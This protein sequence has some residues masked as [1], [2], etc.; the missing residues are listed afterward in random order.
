M[1]GAFSRPNPD[2]D[3]DGDTDEWLLDAARRARL[4]GPKGDRPAGTSAWRMLLLAGVAE[5]EVLRLACAASGTEPADFSRLSPALASL[6]PHGVALKHRVAPLGLRDG[7]LDVATSNP[8]SPSLE[9]ALAFAARQ[10]VRLAA[11]SPSDIL[12][13]QARIYGQLYGAG[14]DIGPSGSTLAPSPP[15][16]MRAPVRPPVARLSGAIPAVDDAPT[17]PAPSAA[18]AGTAAAAPDTVSELADRLLNVAAAEGASEVVLDPTTD[19]GLLMRLRID[20][21]LID[22]FRIAEAQVARVVGALMA[23]CGIPATGDGPGRGGRTAHETPAGTVLYRVAVAIGADERRRLTIRLFSTTDLRSL[24]QLGFVPTNLRRIEMLLRAPSGL[25]MVVGPAGAGLTT[26]LYAAAGA[27]RDAGRRVQSVEQPVEFR[28][29]GIEQREVEGDAP[30]ALASAIE[31]SATDTRAALVV[32]P[33]LDAKALAQCLSGPGR[34]RLTV[35]TLRTAGMP[36]TVAQ[37][38]SLVPDRGAVASALR[39]IVAQRLVRRLCDACAAS[40]PVS[41]LPEAQQ[42]LVYGLP[43]ARLRRPV[44]CALCRNT[45]YRG[46]TAMVSVV[47]WGPA[48][49]SAHESARDADLTAI[50][51]TEG[52]PTLW[53][54]GMTRVLDGVTSLAELLDTLP[55]PA[56]D[57]RS[58]PQQDIDALLSQLLGSPH[59]QPE[60]AAPPVAPEVPPTAEA[61]PVAP[62]HAAEARLRVLVVDD[63][64]ESR[65]LLAMALEAEGL[66][67][68]QA[69]DG[70]AAL[71]YVRRLRPDV[72]LT[73]VALPKLDAV[74]LLAALSA[75]PVPTPVVVCTSQVDAE[76]VAWLLESGARDVVGRDAPIAELVHRLRGQRTTTK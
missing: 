65:R 9:R 76:L 1:T 14:P 19:G 58:A 27:L 57:D 12:A 3:R 68:L 53:D 36:E 62:A 40:Q 7:A 51:R 56:D 45:G 32:T 72:V 24:D 41:E 39:G 16:S 71:S 8:R 46:R 31:S 74:G 10:R 38:L 70:E 61:P 54:A 55:P 22:R 75:D 17:T 63:H 44:G 52:M 67:V 6:L 23:R 25:V 73:E 49:A 69:A 35:A 34:E 30:D 15:P 37:L 59:M 29:E 48:L 21:S 47:E 66:T 18:A 5:A 43:A 42:R 28:I 60:P 64:A 2:S 50:A 26:T 11:A 13:A 33:P 20:G 4:P